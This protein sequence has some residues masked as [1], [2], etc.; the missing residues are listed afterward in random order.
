VPSMLRIRS[1]ARG[2]LVSITDKLG[3]GSGIQRT[4]FGSSKKS[5]TWT[6]KIVKSKDEIKKYNEKEEL[7][8]DTFLKK[9]GNNPENTNIIL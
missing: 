2:Y 9:G 5:K 3:V 4:T 8:K 1:S 6:Q 7:E